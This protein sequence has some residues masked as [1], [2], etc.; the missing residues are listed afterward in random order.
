[1]LARENHLPPL[2]YE[3]ALCVSQAVRQAL[4]TAGVVGDEARVVH[5]G[6]DVERFAGARR[7]GSEKGG[8]LRLLYAGRLAPEKGVHTA[9]GA[10]GIARRE[11]SPIQLTIAGAGSRAYEARLRRLCE[12]LALSEHVTFAGRVPREAMPQL[13]ARFDALLVPSEWPEPLPRIVQEGMAAGLVVLASAVGGI[14]EIVQN[15]SNGLT[16]AAGNA[17]ELAVQLSRA[18]GDPGL[19]ARLSTAAQA[20]VRAQFDIRRTVAEIEAYLG[21]LSN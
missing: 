3:H 8:P 20:T 15:E 1:M 17:A 5:N 2:K 21:V 13:M 7:G 4:Q 16:F 10:L 12:Q 18:C 9:I 14:G 11:G 6:I 19:R